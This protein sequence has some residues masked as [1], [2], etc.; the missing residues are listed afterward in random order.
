MLDGKKLSGKAAYEYIVKAYEEGKKLR[1][2]REQKQETQ[3][4]EN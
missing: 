3:K 2:E 4:E 1:A